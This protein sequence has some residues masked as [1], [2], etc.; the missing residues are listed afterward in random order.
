M[1]EGSGR[2]PGPGGTFSGM[3]EPVSRTTLARQGV[4][5]AAGVAGGIALMTL[6]R[7]GLFGIV[8]GALITVGGLAL[9]GSRSDRN[10]GLAATAVGIATLAT[11]IFGLGWIMRAGGLVLVGLGGYWIWKFVTNLRK[12]M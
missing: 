1:R 6:A 2:D 4:Q 12:R 8:A 3:S 10:T 9:A 7:G 11:G 5:G